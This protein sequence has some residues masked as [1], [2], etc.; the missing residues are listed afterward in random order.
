MGKRPQHT[1]QDDM[2]FQS[3]KD[4]IKELD[5]HMKEVLFI[6]G[7]SASY[8]FKGMRS[9]VRDLK[10]EVINIKAEMKNMKDEDKERDRKSAFFS[11]KLETIPQKIVGI[12]AFII[13]VLTI[14]QSLR[15]LFTPIPAE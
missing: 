14:V 13:M 5:A 3:I 10:Q 4:Q 1:N 7:G 8:E 15:T 9:D 11:V 6:L 12:V 2:D